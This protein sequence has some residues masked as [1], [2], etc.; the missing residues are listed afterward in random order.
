MSRSPLLRPDEWL[1]A[2]P[3]EFRE[4]FATM[5]RRRELPA[6]TAL[7]RREDWGGTYGVISGCLEL[8][9]EFT[10]STLAGLHFAYPGYYI[11]N[12]PIKTGTPYAIT[13][14]ARVDSEVQVVSFS[15]LMQLIHINPEWWKCLATITDHW[16]D[17]ATCSGLD[18]M[19]RKPEARCLAVLLRLGGYRPFEVFQD[20]PRLVPITQKELADNANMSRSTVSEILA[21][22]DDEGL[23]TRGYGGIE[24]LRPHDLQLKLDGISG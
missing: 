14:S 2:Q 5:G 23:I 15:E 18:L 13:V 11:G 17:V 9:I 3:D 19:L 24:I 16:F 6:G 20:T 10:C 1:A 21:R 4:K 22:Y 7:Y 12:R 8:S